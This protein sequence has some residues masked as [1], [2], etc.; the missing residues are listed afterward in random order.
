MHTGAMVRSVCRMYFNSRKRLH[1]FMVVTAVIL[2]G[3]I[4]VFCLTINPYHIET[5]LNGVAI[6]SAFFLLTLSNMNFVYLNENF[7]KAIKVSRRKEIPESVHIR[8]TIFSLAISSIFLTAVCFMLNLF[9]IDILFP[10]IWLIL[11]LFI[12]IIYTLILWN[13]FASKA[14][15]N[16]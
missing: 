2:F 13:L 11:Y 4:N 8:S 14:P 7:T 12:G 1:L 9:G 15:D 6:I 5:T 3:A 16:R 10:L